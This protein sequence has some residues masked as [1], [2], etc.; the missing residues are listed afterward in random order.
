MEGLMRHKITELHNTLHIYVLM[1]CIDEIPQRYFEKAAS[2]W[3]EMIQ[4]G[5]EWNRYKAA[6][7]LLDASIKGGYVHESQVTANGH[8]AIAWVKSTMQSQDSI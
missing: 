5:H 7:R 2:H 8:K 4:N 1:H 6:A 3:T